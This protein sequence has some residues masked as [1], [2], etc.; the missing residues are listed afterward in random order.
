MTPQSLTFTVPFPPRPLR[1]ALIGRGGKHMYDPA[2][3]K[4]AKRQ[5]ADAYCALM[6]IIVRSMQDT[7]QVERAGFIGVL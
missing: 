5:V 1:R 2:E 6:T 4:I 7:C 3:N